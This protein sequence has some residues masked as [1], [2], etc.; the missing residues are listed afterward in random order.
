MISADPGNGSTDPELI[1]RPASWSLYDGRFDGAATASDFNL[2]LRDNYVGGSVSDVCETLLGDITITQA[3]QE[4]TGFLP[5]GAGVYS[6]I[7]DDGT[8]KWYRMYRFITAPDTPTGWRGSAFGTEGSSSGVPLGPEVIWD[9]QEHPGSG[10]GDDPTDIPGNVHATL[11]FYYYPFNFVA[12]DW[13]RGNINAEV[14]NIP[15]SKPMWWAV[16]DEYDSIEEV[17]SVNSSMAFPE[18]RVSNYEYA[19]YDAPALWNNRRVVGLNSTGAVLSDRT[20]T[21]DEGM[22]ATNDPPAI[23][24]AWSYDEHL[25]PTLKFSRGWG[26]AAASS[27]DETTNGI[28]EVFEYDD[29]FFVNMGPPMFGAED[30]IIELAPRTPINTWIRKGCAPGNDLKISSI[31]YYDDPFGSSSEPQEWR[32]KLPK[33]ETFYDLLGN[34]VGTIEH[35]Y[36]HWDQSQLP[37]ADPNDNDE[38][39]DA[40]PPMRWKVRVGPAHTRSPGGAAVRAI[41]GQWFNNRGELVW[42]VSGAMEN[43]IPNASGHVSVSSAD[44]VFLNYH[45][46]DDDGRQTLRVED[47]SIDA[48]GQGFTRQHLVYPGHPDDA[49]YADGTIPTAPYWQDLQ[50]TPEGTLF[51]GDDVPA[52]DLSAT[53]L[54]ML[55]DKISDDQADLIGTG[56]YRQAQ[57]DPLNRVTFTLYNNFGPFKVIHPNGLRDLYH[58]EVESAY[59]R[60]LRA[61]G[62]DFEGGSWGFA[63]QSLYDSEFQGQAFTD[64]IQATIDELEAGAWSGSPYDLGGQVFTSNRLEVISELT[65]NYDTA[66][67]LTGLT[68]ADESESADPLESAVSYDGWGNIL[69]EITPDRLITRYKYDGLGRLHKTFKGSADRHSRWGTA[70]VQDE[71]DDLVLT[72][73]LFYGSSPTDAFL[74]ITK[75]MYRERSLNQYENTEWSEP[76]DGQFGG[77]P[78]FASGSSTPAQSSSGRV[79]HYGYDWRMRRVITKYEDFDGD[80]ATI[81]REERTFLDNLGRVRFTAVYDGEAS[82]TAPSPDIAPGSDLPPATAFLG[83]GVGGNLISLEETVY[84]GAG[85]MVERRRYDPSA[86][87]GYLVTHSYTDHADRALWASSSSGRVTKNVY[88]A[89]GRMV[90]TSEFAGDDTNGGVAVELTRSVNVYG[91]DGNVEQVHFYE[92]TDQTG[93]AGAQSL[94]VAPHRLSSTYTWYDTGSR[95]VATADMGS[96]EF[97]GAAY[98]RMIPS[99]VDASPEVTTEI[100][101]YIGAGSSSG[102]PR[103]ILTG[104]DY[105]DSFFDA[106]TGEVL[107]QITCYW[108][109][110]IGK[111]NAVLSVIDAFKDVGSGTETV[112]FVIDRTEYNRYGQ[113]VLEHKY[114][115]IGGGSSFVSADFELLG[116]MEYTY[117]VEMEVGGQLSTVSTTQVR[118]ITPLSTNTLDMVVAWEDDDST[119]TVDQ[120]TGEVTYTV[121]GKGRFTTG[122]SQGNWISPSAKRTTVIEYGA[123]IIQP[124]FDLPSYVLHPVGPVQLPIGEDDWQYL[125]ISSRPDLVKAV[126]LP[127]PDYGITGDGLGYS[128]FFFYHADGL[129]AIRVDSRGIG[130]Q[131]IYDSDGNL[132]RMSSDDANMPL[133][134]DLGMVDDQLPSNA[135]EYTYDALNRLLSVTAGRDYSDGSFRTDTKSVL[136]Y[137]SLGNMI[138]EQQH[139]YEPDGTVLAGGTVGYAWDTRLRSSSQDPVDSTNNVNR[140]VSITYPAR[141]GTHDGGAHSPRVVTLGY[142]A[143]GGLSDMLSRIESLTSTGGPQG[144]ELGHVA[145]YRYEGISRLAG[146]DLGE[147]PSQPTGTH[148]HTDD[149]DYDIFGRVIDRVVQSFDGGTGGYTTIMDSD[150]GYDLR[151]QRRYERLSQLD[152]PSLGSRANTHSAYYEYD[153]LGRLTGEHYGTLKSNG[154]EGIDHV[155]S[156][157]DPLRQLYGLDTLNRRVGV[158]TAPGVS[159]WEDADNDA[160]VDVGELLTQTHEI[161]E[162]GGLTGLND[163]T[164]TVAVPQD[165]SGA[166]AELNGRSIY[167]DWL[168]RP[169]LVGTHSAGGDFD[170]VFSVTY[171]GFGRVAQR[172]A[173]WPNSDPTLHLQ[174]VESYFYDGVRRIQEV[175]DDPKPGIPPWPVQTNPFGGGGGGGGGNGPE[176]R[177]EAEFV[178]S[179][180]SGQPFDTCHVQVDW[181]DREAWYVQDH[182]TGTVR[183]YTDETGEMARQYRFDAFGKLLGADE[184]P[185]TIGGGLMK[186]FRNRLG[187]QGLFAE[188][189]DADTSAKVLSDASGVELWYQSRSRWYEPGLGRFLTPDPNATGVPVVGSLAMLGTTPSSSAGNGFS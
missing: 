65:P 70:T 22:V 1:A 153:A 29:P 162:R 116:G 35:F 102:N 139:R 68:V 60:E 58:Y 179:A 141:V 148:V 184:F 135:I 108:Y 12:E 129:P 150:F 147:V 20:W 28:V 107:A 176:Q 169:V 39:G 166:I 54:G 134:S 121:S 43:P 127:S 146:I 63:G 72:E 138:S 49:D 7:A 8:V 84:N 128:M 23:L 183:A 155:A 67:R 55:I 167:H 2:D 159:I 111:Q 185:L 90:K 130:M 123:P 24:E 14:V 82:G 122:T 93:G 74:P 64:G 149:R 144:L 186:T 118:S 91:P 181:W 140:L 86:T 9:D 131:Y 142:G 59:L 44:E 75:W 189:V 180:V 34:A 152:H 133:V 126:H 177:T 178:W 37:D 26:A 136:A 106:T 109:D 92:R 174:R 19:Q 172:K 11:A 175:F 16:V 170:A 25:R 32:A 21:N 105:P 137:D 33:V 15:R 47:I 66:G 160:V 173:P 100:Q 110:R 104:V 95:V 30:T 51:V 78:E 83:S 151:G 96:A 27:I 36:G 48:S 145:T 117:E 119:R 156:L 112:D 81:Y 61:M 165:E 88:D 4:T 101:D 52:D 10:A 80:D 182:Q 188:R 45:Q 40:Q 143:A 124:D 79:E 97:D 17:L 187:H 3:N 157:I 13:S 154:F 50:S 89:L 164:T 120:Q 114:H 62:V 46:Y 163:G 115:Y 94:D 87:G 168:G 18:D 53:D 38:P 77:S 41:D 99:R 6:A 132:I 76:S 158:G 71:D 73:K 42:T 125:G 161:D 85:Q 56:M 57:A 171:D 5:A 31:E 69:L 103:S 98:D 113:K